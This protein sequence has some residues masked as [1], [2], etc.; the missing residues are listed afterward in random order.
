MSHAP[1]KATTNIIV[2]IISLIY[3]GKQG[4]IH[5]REGKFGKYMFGC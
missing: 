5:R 4:R 2:G 3:G 1:S